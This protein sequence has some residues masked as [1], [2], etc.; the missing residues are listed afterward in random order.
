MILGS[1]LI[2][3]AMLCLLS[4]LIIAFITIVSKSLDKSKKVTF[5]VP[6][7]LFLLYVIIMIISLVLLNS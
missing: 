4:S 3:F 5:K 6:A 7:I 2:I 1:I